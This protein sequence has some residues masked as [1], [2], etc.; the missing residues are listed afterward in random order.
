MDPLVKQNRDLSLRLQLSQ[1]WHGVWAKAY[2]ALLHHRVDFRTLP[3]YHRTDAL[4]AAL[5]QPT[6]EGGRTLIMQY[7]ERLINAIEAAVRRKTMIRKVV[8][9]DDPPKR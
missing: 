7:L 4:D 2:V 6:I 5:K 1:A 9:N 3:E 8:D